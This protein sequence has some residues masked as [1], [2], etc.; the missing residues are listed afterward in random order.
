MNVAPIARQNIHNWCVDVGTKKKPVKIPMSICEVDRG[1][2]YGKTVDSQQTSGMIRHA[3]YRPDEN[4]LEIE[5]V[6]CPR[7]GIDRSM[8]AGGPVS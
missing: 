3:C 1:Q 8:P 4:R 2:A 5:Q 6:G 7:F